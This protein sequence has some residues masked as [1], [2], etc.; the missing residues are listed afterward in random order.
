M[1]YAIWQN[2][3][4]NVLVDSCCANY[5]MQCLLGD[6]TRKVPFIFIYFILSLSY[7]TITQRVAYLICA[8]IWIIL[9]ILMLCICIYC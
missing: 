6:D 5:F 9:F 2:D 3:G 7:A 4:K 8:Q 1:A